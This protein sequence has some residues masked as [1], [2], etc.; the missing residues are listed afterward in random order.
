MIWVKSLAMGLL[1]LVL[2][3]VLTPFVALAVGNLVIRR[4]E[5][6]AI[7]FDIVAFSRS[8][9]AW[10]LFGLVFLAGFCWEYRRL[11]K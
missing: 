7:G 4:K 2:A 1:F 8:P 9:F 10:I 5:G 3:I 6:A 11:S